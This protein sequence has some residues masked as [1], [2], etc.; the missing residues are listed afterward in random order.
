M[1]KKSKKLTP[2]QK[3]YQK[4]VKR[5]KQIITRAEKRGYRFENKQSIIPPKPKRITQASIRRLKEIKPITLYKKSTYLTDTGEV[6]KGTIG[7]TI[8]RKES[9][10]KGVQK[11]RQNLSKLFSTRAKTP[12]TQPI[13]SIYDILNDVVY[14]NILD[15]IN[16]VARDHQ[17]AA[18]KLKALLQHETDQFGKTNVLKSL[19][20]SPQDA[21]E[22]AQVALNYNPGDTRHDDAIRELD[23]LIRGSI[24]TME[25]S[26]EL[27][28]SILE[29]TYTDYG[30]E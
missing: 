18:N 3:E 2:L 29:D 13:P 1:A 4:Q 17:K 21:I 20:N 11:R 15:M 9:A 8:E 27:Q 30:E 24:P 6:V 25:E 16:S 7:R 10:R 5:I 14:N 22:A 26:K 12:S 19:M 23:L 28:D